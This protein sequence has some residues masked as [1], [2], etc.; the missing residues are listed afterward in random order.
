MVLEVNISIGESKYFISFSDEN[1]RMTSIHF[2]KIK[3]E[4]ISKINRTN[5]ETQCIRKKN[6]LTIDN[7]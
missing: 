1:S 3:N 7:G 2:S 6:I 5:V 4:A